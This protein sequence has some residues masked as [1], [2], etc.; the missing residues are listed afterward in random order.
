MP[1]TEF[2]HHRRPSTSQPKKAKRYAQK[3]NIGLTADQVREYEQLD[4]C[5]SQSDR[6]HFELAH[7]LS[8]KSKD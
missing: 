8:Q 2:A 5:Q 4:A 1:L 6:V 3:V 7:G